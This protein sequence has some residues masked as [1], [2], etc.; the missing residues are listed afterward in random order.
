MSHLLNIGDIQY[1]SLKGQVPADEWQTRVQL[2]ALFRLVPFMGWDDLSMQ[3]C[4]AR[5]GEHFLFGPDCFL[6]EEVTA[7][8]L[9]K[10]DLQGNKVDDSPFKV[11][12]NLW[13][14][15]RA[16]F[17]VRPDAHTVIHTHDDYVA[18]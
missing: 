18:A 10:I 2:A 9:V 6:F 17:E 8:S 7:S 12:P 16:V 15:M 11:G 14:P 3:L 13:H 4:A 1:P 5:V